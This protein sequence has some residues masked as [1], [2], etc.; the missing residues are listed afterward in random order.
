MN[1]PT[2]ST[3]IIAVLEGHQGTI[4]SIKTDKDFVYSSSKDWTVHIWKKEQWKP[5]ETLHHNSWVNCLFVDKTHVLTGSSDT[6]VKI[7]KKRTWENV[8]SLKHQRFSVVNDVYA[9]TAN[10]YVALNDRSVRVYAKPSWEEKTKLQHLGIVQANRVNN[11]NLL[12]SLSN[13]TAV[14]WSKKKWEIINTIQH[15]SFRTIEHLEIDKERIYTSIKNSIKIWD[16]NTQEF[17]SEIKTKKGIITL[18][19]DD[20]LLI[21][22]CKDKKV[23]YWRKKNLKEIASIKIDSSITSL[24][25][26][27]NYIF[28]G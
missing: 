5:V 15:S 3:D 22:G 6:T 2:E 12:S 14:I 7:W 24:H 10:C 4:T 1:K 26:D 19:V 28:V 20:T 17:I 8:V 11:L 9:D 18:A 23:Y 25:S 21:A 13:G 27:N 16:I